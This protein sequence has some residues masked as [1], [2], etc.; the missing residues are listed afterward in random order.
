VS[1]NVGDAIV[2][3]SPSG[4]V[5][6]TL[7]DFGHAPDVYAATLGEVP[8]DSQ[9]HFDGE[10]VVPAELNPHQMPAD[11]VPIPVGSGSYQLEFHP[12][13][14]GAA[15]G[16]SNLLPFTVTGGAPVAPVGENDGGNGLAS[17]LV[18]LLAVGS[19]GVAALVFTTRLLLR[20]RKAAPV[21]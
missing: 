6:V 12:V 13:D 5:R 18:V 2:R 14:L 17:V 20:R 16:S 1:G 19:L 15:E 10:F 9:G 7:W 4:I 11:S 21:L 3:Q 8:Y